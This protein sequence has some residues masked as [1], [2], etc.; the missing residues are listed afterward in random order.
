[1]LL[2]KFV[3]R[4]VRTHSLQKKHAREFFLEDLT[5]HF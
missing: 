1:M 5:D 4:P 2:K 3:N